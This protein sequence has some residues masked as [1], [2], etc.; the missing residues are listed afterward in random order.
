[1]TQ[2]TAQ[3]AAIERRLRRAWKRQRHVLAARGVCHLLLWTAGLG[4][5]DFLIDWLLVLPGYGRLALLCVN[6]AVLGW[7]AW[8]QWLR[9]VRRYDPLRVALRVE[10]RHPDLRSL[11]VSYVQ[12][13][14]AEAARAHLSPDLVRAAR[15]LAVEATRPIDFREIVHW[16]DVRRV[17]LFCGGAVLVAAALSLNWPDFAATFARRLFNPKAEVAYPTR[18]TVLRVTGSVTVPQGAPLDLQARAGGVL[19]KA[20][21]LW[22]RPAGGNWERLLMPRTDG[23]TYAYRFEQV[24]RD[25]TYRVRLGDATSE[26][27]TV[28]VVPAPRIV[29][30]RVDLA[31][32]DYTGLADETAENLHLEVPAGTTAAVRVTLDRPLRRAEAVAES[33]EAAPMTLGPEGRTASRTWTVDES[34]QFR[35]RWTEA[36]HGFAYDDAVHH[37]IRAIPD[38]APR[39]EILA[40]ARD[41]KATTAKRLDLRYRAADDYGVARAAVVYQVNDGPEQRLP[42]RTFQGKRVEDAWPWTLREAIPTLAEG[43][44]VTFAVEVA[45]NRGGGDGPQVARSQSLRLDIVSVAEYLRYVAEERARLFKDIRD[46]YEDETEASAQ[47][48]TLKEEAP[49]PPANE[50]G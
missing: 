26:T 18:T 15:R 5:A 28:R 19:P 47:V 16:R 44:T 24:L 35:F 25:M 8:H 20:G 45:D 34:V 48:G 50:G 30:T 2:T 17:A 32:P 37:V 36:E 38:A 12:L 31:Y 22:I 27:F 7:V 14:E 23:G 33:G 42:A 39:A 49:R 40:P 1:M 4:L 41:A 13:D 10:D 9:H 43:D 29:E 6:V 46:V 21:T 11:L 3:P